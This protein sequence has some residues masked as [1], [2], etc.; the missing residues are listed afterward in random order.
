MEIVI[1]HKI[2]KRMKIAYMAKIIDNIK[3][4]VISEINLGWKYLENSDFENAKNSL[5]KA[6][7]W[8]SNF[9][10]TDFLLG[11]VSIS[12]GEL[13]KAE[14]YLDSAIQKQPQYLEPLYTKL[15]IMIKNGKYKEAVDLINAGI[16]SNSWFKFFMI[17][18]L[19]SLQMDYAKAKKYLEMALAINPY[20][21]DL[22]I[23]LGD[24]YKE[25]NDKTGA[26]NYYK[27]AGFIDPENDVFSS[28]L[29]MLNN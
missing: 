8:D 25:L 28:R 13:S 26:E 9:A 14:I 10:L 29:Q 4:N 2:G 18:R 22:L 19:Y 5:L 3:P 7:N 11:K 15:D 12:T 23:F 24:T 21:F 1:F 17:G 16:T 6:K 20:N 27:Q